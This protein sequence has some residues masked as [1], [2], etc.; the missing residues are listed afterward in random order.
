MLGLVNHALEGFLRDTYGSSAW[1]GIVQRAGFAADRFEPLLRYPPELTNMIL[2][3]ADAQLG[4]ARDTILEDLGTWLVSRRS[5]GRLRRLLRFGGVTFVDFLHSL[6]ELPDRAL[7]AMPDFVVPDLNL[8]EQGAGL[9]SM[10]FDDPFSGAQHVVAGALRAMADD[11]GVLVLIECI[12]G[13]ILVQLLDAEFAEAR[14]F[15]LGMVGN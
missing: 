7:L 13:G 5:G 15:D 9:F 10:R 6:E 12:E 1:K 2:E 8:T 3:S 4:R 14:H 11:Y